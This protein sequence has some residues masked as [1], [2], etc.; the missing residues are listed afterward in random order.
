M[1]EELISAYDIRGTK[2][3]GLTVECAWNIGKALADWLPTAGSVAVAY[4][5][6][7]IDI[8]RAIIEGLRLQGRNVID[9]GNGGK[10]AAK[11]YVA[12]A[13]LSGAVVV[14]FDELESQITIELY[15]DEVKLI[16][17]SSGLQEIRD[18]IEAGNFVPAAV[19]GELTQLV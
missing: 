16:D 18:L 1:S 3:T 10:D 19:K 5:P 12:T 17:S 13:K 4:V 7:Q 14:G 8:A 9:G 2:E 15:N 11:S 6:T